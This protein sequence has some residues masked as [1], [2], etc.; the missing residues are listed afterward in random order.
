MA[1]FGLKL[2]NSGGQNYEQAQ[3]LNLFLVK[4]RLTIISQIKRLV[5]TMIN[6]TGSLKVVMRV[7]SNLTS[8]RKGN[9]RHATRV[10]IILT[11]FTYGIFGLH[12]GK[13]DRADVNVEYPRHDELKIATGF[14]TKKHTRHTSFYVL[15]IVNIPTSQGVN[16][17]R[18][19][20]KNSIINILSDFTLSKPIE[21]L[22]WEAN[23]EFTPH[24]V[25]VKYFILP[26]QRAWIADLVSDGRVLINYEQRKID[27]YT[28]RSIRNRLDM[29]Y[30]AAILLATMALVWMYVEARKQLK[31]GERN[32]N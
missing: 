31:Q 25:T 32:S 18:T 4:Y 11:G 15:N 17:P 8:S 3:P 6:D 2:S 5:K 24:L 27:F 1:F 16:D 7:I 21:Q 13:L 9:W 14:L 12:Y 22:G 28:R 26:S 30:V 10:I 29:E 19:V 20:T 23:G